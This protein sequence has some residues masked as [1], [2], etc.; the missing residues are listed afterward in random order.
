MFRYNHFLKKPVKLTPPQILF[1]GF[2]IVILL[3]AFLLTLP[4]ATVKPISII[5]AFFTAVSATTVTGLAVVDTGTTFTIFGQIVIMLMI[6]IG[7]LGFLTLAVM[8][9]L[10]LGK[11]IGLRERLWVQEAFNLTNIGGIVRLIKVMFIFSMTFELA[12]TCLLSFR[13]IP[14]YGFIKGVYISLFHAISAFNNA[15]FSLFPNSLINYVNDP[16]INITITSLFIIGGLG[17][18][19]IFDIWNK[20]RYK[21]LSIHSKLMILGTIITNGVAILLIFLM[22]F[23]NPQTIGSMSLLDKF[24]ASYFQAVTPRT[25]GFN[26]LDIA[27]MHESSLSLMMLLMFIGAG[28]ASTGSG[29]KL[30]TMIIILISVLHFLKGNKEPVI[31]RRTIKHDVVIK[32]LSISFISLCF[33]FIT[34]FLLTMTEKA[35]FIDIVFETFSAFGTV[36]LSMGLTPDLTFLGKVILSILMFIGRVGSLTIVFIFMKRTKSPIRYPEGEVFVG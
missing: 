8:V 29:I 28:S 9:I 36:G 35:P 11:K 20:R 32:A 6:Q 4:I 10:L 25:A 23:G 31:Y 27:N 34:I 17:F 24:W 21:L 16:L 12:A 30:T 14:E 33:V 5:D 19:V 26:S 1:F 22:E 3:G 13:W 15:G 2:C 7:G 18:T